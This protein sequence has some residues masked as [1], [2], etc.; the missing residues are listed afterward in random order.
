MA[1]DVEV[2][3]KLGEEAAAAPAVT[4]PSEPAEKP[5][6]T[7]VAEPA[8]ET[9]PAETPSEGQPVEEQEVELD[10]D[11]PA[12]AS[13]DF[14]KF[15]PVLDAHPEF[16]SEL[17]QIIGREKAY[18]ELGT[19]SEVRSIIERVPTL[20]DAETLFADAE[21][22]RA[23]SETFRESPEVFNSSLKGSDPLAY[24]RYVQ[25][26]PE[27]L[28]SEDPDLW[29]AQARSYVGTVLTNLYGLARQSNDEALLAAVQAV[30][31][32]PHLGIPIGAHQQIPQRMN[33]E[34]ERLRKEL[35]E[36]NQKDAEA[37]YNNFVNSADEEIQRFCYTTIDEQLRKALPKASDEQLGRMNAE[38]YSKLK[39]NLG[40]QPQFVSRLENYKESARKGRQGTADYKSLVDFSTSRI[41]LVVPKVLKSVVDEWTKKVLQFN[42]SKTEQ[43]K[44][45]AQ[46]SRDAGSGPQGTSAAAGAAAPSNKPR[47]QEDIFRELE[48]GTYAAKR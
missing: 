21:N 10:I 18:S 1:T 5:K 7:P 44:A 6:E 41:K 42:N 15:K 13:G 46:N 4:P 45:I 31:N 11:Q 43:K 2:L 12:E 36:R 23:L 22:K 24:Q 29:A 9:P 20:E 30:A 47:T 37:A 27:V 28:A 8:K 39:G 48:S 33:S 14:E 40:S 17:K 16:K 25:A 26:M 32:S 3:N 19:F 34:T 35:E 38:V